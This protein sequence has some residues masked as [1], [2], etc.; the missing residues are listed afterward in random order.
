MQMGGRVSYNGQD[1]QLWD[2]PKAAAYVGLNSHFG[3]M[4]CKEV[5]AFSDRCQNPSSNR[6]PPGTVEGFW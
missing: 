6:F 2:V 5:L 1:L 3:E 4:T